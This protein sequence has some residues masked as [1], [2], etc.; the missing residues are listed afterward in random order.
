[1]S[2]CIS[3]AA[4]LN[5]YYDE[6]G[7]PILKYDITRIILIF[8]PIANT[9]FAIFVIIFIKTII[10]LKNDNKKLR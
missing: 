9:L 2:A 7:A 1:M 10:K 8:L 3:F 5:N 6:D 4:L